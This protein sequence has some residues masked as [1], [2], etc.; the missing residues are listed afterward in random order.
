MNTFDPIAFFAQV[1]L[2]EATLSKLAFCDS[3][4]PSAVG[5]WLDSLH[6][7][8]I[9]RTS[10]LLYKNIPE[11]NQLK[12]DAKSRLDIA[13]TLRP[14][15]QHCIEGLTRDF[16]HQPLV[17]PQGAQKTSIIAQALQKSLMDCYSLSVR[18]L[19]EKSKGKNAGNESLALA[20]HRAITSIGLLF[21]RSYQI[22]AQT[23]HGLWLTLHGYYQIAKY[24]NLTETCIE[25]PLLKHANRCS[26][27]AAYLRVLML[28]TAR[29][30]QLGHFELEQTYDC[31]ETW[32]HHVKVLPEITSDSKNFYVVNVDNDKP[33]YYKSRFDG[34]NGEHLLELNF[35]KLMGPLSAYANGSRGPD[36]LGNIDI[37]KDF[38]AALLEHLIDTWGTIAQRKQERRAI[39]SFAE[40]CIGLNDCHYFLSGEKNFKELL[41]TEDED[42]PTWRGSNFSSS[43]PLHKNRAERPIYKVSIQNIS[44][45]G[46]CLLWKGEVPAIVETG[47]IL[48]IRDVGRR[49]WH[50]GI[51]RWIRKLKNSSQIGVRLLSNHAK[52]YAIAQDLANGTE[53][54][55]KQALYI[56][57]G[58]FGESPASILTATIPFQE[59]SQVLLRNGEKTSAA[60]LDRCLLSTASIRQFSY[61]SVDAHHSANAVKPSSGQTRANG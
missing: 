24:Y 58:K 19:C 41:V 21:F 9:S 20:L 45:G 26:I 31:L 29:S 1:K 6:A 28:S 54:D 5:R 61:N 8:N 43:S 13:E 51:V 35:Q 39:S 18:D 25:D 40:V 47:E 3:N 17:L 16:L 50:V 56:P 38:P 2:P 48:G 23:P 14:S 55:Y 57:P 30:N 53:Q 37:P 49:S 33:P 60:M 46:Y 22:Y 10:V 4:K 36:K 7:T 12:T 42:T 27:Q 11:I 34:K 59:S 52:P 44:S 32:C 15:V